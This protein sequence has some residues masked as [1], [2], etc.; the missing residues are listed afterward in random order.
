M[1]NVKVLVTAFVLGGNAMEV[2]IDARIT[3]LY[4]E[5]RE[6]IYKSRGPRATFMIGWFQEDPNS[7]ERRNAIADLFSE[8]A[9]YDESIKLAA[10]L[11][12]LIRERA[13][14]IAERAKIDLSKLSTSSDTFNVPDSGGISITG[15]GN[16]IIGNVKAGVEPI[17]PWPVAGN[18]RK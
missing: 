6:S 18:R 10:R 3:Y 1:D 8:A 14:K 4:K 2:T 12:D 17:N 5:L 13:P 9:I 15:T 7:A 16:I 11:I